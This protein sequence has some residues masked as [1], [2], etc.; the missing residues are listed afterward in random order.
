MA[1]RVEVSEPCWVGDAELASCA[2]G[3]SA[4]VHAYYERGVGVRADLE[5]CPGVGVSE[6]LTV[7]F[8]RRP[9]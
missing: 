2:L 5:R 3:K 9:G 4:R 1:G 6:Q 8:D 7:A